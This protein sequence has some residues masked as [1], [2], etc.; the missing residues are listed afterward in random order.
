MDST[1]YE[2]IFNIKTTGEQKKSNK[3]AHYH[4]YEP[5]DYT[6]LE[7]LSS[8]FD[9][10]KKDHIL[11]FGC[12]KGRVAFYLN[13]FFECSVTGI[14]MNKMYYGN[15]QK[16]LRKYR[17]TNN[18]KDGEISFVNCLAE[19]YEIDCDANK[20]YF[21]NPF[22]VQIF[23][24]ITDNIILSCKTRPR[25]VEL[26]LYYP[27]LDYLYF[28]NNYTPYLFDREIKVPQLC[29]N[30]LRQCLVRYFLNPAA[31]DMG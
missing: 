22:S 19:D 24:K 7:T 30:D 17:K 1:D 13:Y 21:F 6:V 3:I 4:I 12:G 27:S 23:R 8:N 11:D 29:I 5:T 20:F 15:A 26:I 25:P 2:I 18:D 14:E 9:F 28:L 31:V 16:N 10:T